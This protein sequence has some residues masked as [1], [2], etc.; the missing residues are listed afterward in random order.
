[1]TLRELVSKPP[2]AVTLVVLAA[3]VGIGYVR[4]LGSAE[5]IRLT[6]VVSADEVIVATQLGGAIQELLVDEG[7]WVER[8]DP[9]AV[10]ES[11]ELEAEER[12]QRAAIDRLRVKL[13]QAQEK[14]AVEGE[15]IEVQIAGA[16][17][18]LQFAR[19]QYREALLLRT[20]QERDAAY[21]RALAEEGLVPRQEQE[22]METELSLSFVRVQSSQDQVLTA[23]V[24][25]ELARATERE[26][27]LAVRDAEQISAELE[28]ARAE[29]ERIVARLRHSE[30]Q[31][32]RAGRVNLRVATEG[33]SVKAGDP[34]VTL[35]DLNDVWVR[36][37][38]EEGQLDRVVPAQ[39]VTV[40]L[41][42]G[43]ELE[44]EVT[45]ISPVAEFATR[46][47]ASREQRD[48]RT[49][50][51]KVAVPN[52]DLRVHPGMTAYVLLP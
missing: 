51:I 42:S 2:V 20:Q 52:P 24:E 19:S 27:Q 41:A 14:T 48:I 47:D 8:G 37:Q 30:I 10:L 45:F 43:E 29:L 38:L 9:I 7:D 44:G 3:L 5:P 23:E 25:L 50:S 12:R 39:K 36:A 26:L 46:R 16:E 33:E 31:A 32:P 28:G 35:V 34:L 15:R 6:G 22:K 11:E 17:A 40:V 49:F 21:N 4:T 13:E 18:R 1:V